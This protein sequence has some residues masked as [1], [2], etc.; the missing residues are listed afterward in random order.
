MIN[1]DKLGKI[2]Q[3]RDFVKPITELQG[4]CFIAVRHDMTWHD[5]LTFYNYEQNKHLNWN[6]FIIHFS[7]YFVVDDEKGSSWVQGYLPIRK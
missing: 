6:T 3:H 2:Q 7:M 4:Q 1:C 5:M